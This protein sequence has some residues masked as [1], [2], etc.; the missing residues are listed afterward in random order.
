[1]GVKCLQHIGR[2]RLGWLLLAAHMACAAMVVAEMPTFNELGCTEAVISSPFDR[3]VASRPFFFNYS[4][5]VAKSLVAIDLPALMAGELI[6]PT[7]SL[8]TFSYVDFSWIRAFTYLE[9]TS[10]QWFAIGCLVNFFGQGL[11]KKRRAHL[12]T[13]EI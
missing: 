1:M 11:A 4:S 2:Y 3:A 12:P 13:R 6:L 10:I 7:N 8:I 5:A 9:T